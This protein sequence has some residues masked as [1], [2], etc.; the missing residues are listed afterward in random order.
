MI[1]YNRKSSILKYKL[2][3]PSLK[4]WFRSKTSILYIP[5]FDFDGQIPFLDRILQHPFLLHASQSRSNL[6]NLILQIGLC[7]LNSPSILAREQQQVPRYAQE[8][9]AIRKQLSK[10]SYP[11]ATHHYPISLCQASLT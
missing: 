8:Q 4:T 1:F 9:L 5:L 7:D 6:E 11:K 2:P 3:M 10:S